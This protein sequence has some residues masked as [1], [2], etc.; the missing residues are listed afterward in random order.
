MK[1][2]RPSRRLRKAS[3]IGLLFL[4]YAVRPEHVGDFPNLAPET[5]AEHSIFFGHEIPLAGAKPVHA[6]EDYFAAAYLFATS[7]QFTTL[8]NAAM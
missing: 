2:T 7:S 5:F 4:G 6:E 8:Q 3:T 1:S